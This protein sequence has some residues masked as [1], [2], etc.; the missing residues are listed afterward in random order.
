[1]SYGFYHVLHIICVIAFVSSFTLLLK[2][3]GETKLA[4]I[5]NG[6]TGLVILISGMGL[7]AKAGFGFDT[8]VI[9]KLVIWLSLVVMIPVT[10]KR[11]PGSKGKV[12]KIALGL[13]FVAVYLVSTKLM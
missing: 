10:A 4:K 12:Y 2:G 13:I 8:W 6:V 11:F 5:A 7:L 9:G 3:D 1:M